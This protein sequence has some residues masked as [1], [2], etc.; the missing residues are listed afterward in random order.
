MRDVSAKE[1]KGTQCPIVSE[2]TRLVWI[3]HGA[4]RSSVHL[5][6]EQQPNG[7]LQSSQ[8]SPQSKSCNDAKS[9]TERSGECILQIVTLRRGLWVAKSASQFH[10]R[11]QLSLQYNAS[12]TA[13]GVLCG[14]FREFRQLFN[15]HLSSRNWTSSAECAS[16][17]W[18][19]ILIVYYVFWVRYSTSLSI[20]ILSFNINYVDR[21]WFVWNFWG[22]H[23][24]F[25]NRNSDLIRWFLYADRAGMERSFLLFLFDRIDRRSK[26]HT[27]C[28]FNI[29][30]DHGSSN[31]CKRKS[32]AREVGLQRGSTQSISPN[33]VGRFV[34]H[35]EFF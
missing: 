24:G 27:Y 31:G 5:L 21:V 19:I 35:S 18:R 1:E 13:T 12:T 6:F 14:V 11:L 29:R 9:L 3:Q 34:T 4:S 25:G 33:N 30:G 20:L 15:L 7:V 23:G 10:W 16:V 8:S 28:G 17:N 22:R 32:Y 26:M 2:L